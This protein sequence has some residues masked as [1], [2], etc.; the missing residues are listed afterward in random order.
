MLMYL[1]AGIAALAMIGGLVY[2]ERKAGGDSVRAELQ[3][4]LTACQTQVSTMG[5]QITTQN[6]AVEALRVEG[7]K[8]AQEA[9]KALVI[10]EGKVKVW[11]DQSSRLTAVISKRQGPAPKDCKAALTD[12]RE[13]YK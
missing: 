1:I 12:I 6:Q 7:A 9:A 2:G 13:S 8:K 11:Q 5:Q 3:P 10:A 4:K